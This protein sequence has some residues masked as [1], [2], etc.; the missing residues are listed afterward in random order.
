MSAEPKNLLQ[1]AVEPQATWRALRQLERLLHGSCTV[2]ARGAKHGGTR[3]IQQ[4][5]PIAGYL[6]ALRQLER[7][8][9][10]SCTVSA[11]R[12]KPEPRACPLCAERVGISSQAV[13]VHLKAH[14]RCV[15]ASCLLQ[16]ACN[17][18]TCQ[19]GR[20]R[21]SSDSAVWTAAP[22]SRG[23]QIHATEGMAP[24]ELPH[25]TLP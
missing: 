8:L 15:R 18:L 9:H 20:R 25:Q 17:T 4:C 16:T 1:Y 24:D 23:E 5:P 22:C 13:A 2:S 11:R 3:K 6:E 19:C 10:G 14:H 12:A 21:S 7:R